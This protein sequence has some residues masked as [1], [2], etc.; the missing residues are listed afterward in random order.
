MLSLL[1]L[2]LAPTLLALL[3]YPCLSLLACVVV[4]LP[5]PLPSILSGPRGPLPLHL[6]F[7]NHLATSPSSPTF[8]ISVVFMPSTPAL[9]ARLFCTSRHL[10]IVLLIH[11]S[12]TSLS[13]RTLLLTLL[14]L[15]YLYASFR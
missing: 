6:P 14:P 4:V 13:Y 12:P 1:P 10:S 5:L 9:H 11:P 3:F 7:V 15:P 8:I 2:S